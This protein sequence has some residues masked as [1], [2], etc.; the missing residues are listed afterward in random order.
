M[1]I[2]AL[3]QHPIE[4]LADHCKM[5]PGIPLKP[6]LAHPT[7][8]LTEILDRFENR[9]FTCEFKYDGERTQVRNLSDIGIAIILLIYTNHIHRF[10]GLKM[11]IQPFTVAILKICLGDTRMS[12]IKFHRYAKTF[13]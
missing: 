3:L 7:K 5:T 12:W 13:S 4:E 2:P 6:M 9:K 10:I 1:I 8:A 11:G